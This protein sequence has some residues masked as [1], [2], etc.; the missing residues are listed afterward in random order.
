MQALNKGPGWLRASRQSFREGAMQKKAPETTQ[1]VP[2]EVD[3]GAYRVGDPEEFGR[4]MLKLMEEGSKLLSDLLGRSNGN[5]GPYSM[6]SETSEAIKLFSEVA[7][8]WLTDPGKV[9]ATQSALLRDYLQLAGATAQRMGGAEALPV[10]APEAGD[11]R[12][13]DPEWSRN[14]YFDFWK[15]AYLI[16][17]RWLDQVLDETEGLDERTRQRAEFYLKQ[18]ASAL[19]PTNF[20][21][22]NP[23][24]LR[25][26][27]ASNGRN[28]LHGMANFM[29][30]LKKSGDVLSISQTDVEAFEVGRNIA[31][32]P[33]KVV[34]QNELIQLI[35]Y[36]PSTESVHATPLLIVPPWINKFY[37]LDLGPQKSFI[38][39][40]VGKGFTVFIVSWVNPDARLKDKTFEEYMTE[41][42]L[43]ATDAVK[44][45]T[46]SEKINVIGYC[47]GGTLLGTTLAYLAARGE[48]PFASA[49]FFAAQVDF[50]KAGDLLLFIDDT[51]LKAL[52][53]MMAERGY[54]DGARMATVFNMLRPK[55]LI[56]PY[57]V[58][59]YMLGKK[60]FPFDLLF[61]N[62]D[63][64]RMTPANHN[65]Y[66]RE[67]YHE[68]KLARGQM[69]IGGV[70]LD[71]GKVKLPIYEL[72]AKED[73]IAPAKSVFIGSRLFG[74]PV[75]YVL[76]GSG[77][78]AG[79]I[80]PPDKPKY[81]YWTNDKKAATLEAWQ[82]SATEHPG[83]WWPHYAGWLAEHSGAKVPART[84][85][86]K[87][88]AIEDAPGSYV[89]TK[90]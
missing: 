71:L 6:A 55:D 25:E 45:E 26:T 85:G 35:Q 50:T 48:E 34:F 1:P 31:T 60:P 63:S 27:L 58:N 17:T 56:W 52:S 21:V 64:T 23:V 41:G 28:L 72:C 49:T 7:Q 67:F 12:F 22:T 81:Q 16:T 66:L 54:L 32:S 65:F 20:P 14:P 18:M 43:A 89:K 70:K 5:G 11:N 19:S 3:F 82:E 80:N 24:V 90:S 73:H 40:M 44:R 10:A 4:N 84:P 36:A 83:S 88:G 77:H 47:V 69:S 15:Q 42:L 8:H 75:T 46:G 51:Q 57:I 76:A 39:Y 13:N 74:G 86:A 78:I 33:G 2:V 59:N 30:D 9:T 38:R 62:Q 29:H 61:W 87:L 68:N 37:I 79:V 53:E